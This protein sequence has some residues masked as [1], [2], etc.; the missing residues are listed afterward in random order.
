MKL[1]IKSTSTKAF[2]VFAA[3]AFSTAASAQNELVWEAF[4]DYRPGDNTS[5][6]ASD[7]DLR[8]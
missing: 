5:E 6:N 8:I 2:A 7:Y 4:N 3:L 1:L